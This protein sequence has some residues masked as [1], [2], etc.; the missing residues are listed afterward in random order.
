MKIIILFL[1]IQLIQSKENLKQVE[2]CSERHPI[3]LFHGILGSSINADITITKETEIPEYCQIQGKNIPLWISPLLLI[4]KYKECIPKYLEM[5]YDEYSQRMKNRKGIHTY[6]ATNTSVEGISILTPNNKIFSSL[7]RIFADIIDHLEIMGYEDTDDLQAAAFDWRILFQN[8][9][10]K[11][12]LTK[13]I[14]LIVKKQRKKVI[15][16]GHS[17]GGLVIHDYLEEMKQSWI[18]RY[19]HKVITLSTPWNGSLKALRCLL[20]GDNFGLSEFILS[21][22]YF[23]DTI[24]SFESIYGLLPKQSKEKENKIIIEIDNKEYTIETILEEIKKMSEKEIF[25]KYSKELLE[26]TKHSYSKR[27]KEY[28]QLC[29]YGNGIETEHKLFYSSNLTLLSKEISMKGDGTVELESLQGCSHFNTDFV[30]IME[31]ENESHVEILEN[32]K[33]IQRIQEEVCSDNDYDS[34]TLTLFEKIKL[35]FSHLNQFLLDLLF[36]FITFVNNLLG[37]EPSQNKIKT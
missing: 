15:L 9:H 37:F 1:L 12:D 32:E 10:W 11:N 18:D 2:Y 23:L 35:Y 20:S 4:P 17:M 24:R 22:D 14:E 5:E 29:I 8:D 33:V 21:N 26:F 16:I 36:D 25:P 28:Q 27:T 19:I 13:R 6:Y 3:F 7:V 30:E 31:I 34:N